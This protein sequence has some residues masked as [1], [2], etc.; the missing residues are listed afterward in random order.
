MKEFS[1]TNEHCEKKTNIVYVALL[2]SSYLQALCFEQ[3]IIEIS[4]STNFSWQSQIYIKNL[5]MFCNGI[6]Y[7]SISSIRK[8][9]IMQANE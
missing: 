2:A 6:E 5:E 7:F 1:A 8:F 9:K 3:K 4:L